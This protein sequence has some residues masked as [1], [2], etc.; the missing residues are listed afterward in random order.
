LSGWPGSVVYQSLINRVVQSEGGMVPK[1]QMDERGRGMTAKTKL[2]LWVCAAAIGLGDAPTKASDSANEKCSEKQML[3]YVECMVS[4]ENSTGKEVN[5]QCYEKYK[6]D[7]ETR[8][9]CN[10]LVKGNL[11]NSIKETLSNKDKK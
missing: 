11:K 2:I 7:P 6:L 1:H 3:D 10:K 9:A 8:S 5:S 4:V